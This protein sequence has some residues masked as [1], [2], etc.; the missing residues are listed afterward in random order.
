[1]SDN[2]QVPSI[3]ILEILLIVFIILKLCDVISWSWW[4]VFSPVWIPIAVVVVMFT[5]SLLK[6]ILS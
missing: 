6:D 3:G 2:E 4:V 1:M 5:T